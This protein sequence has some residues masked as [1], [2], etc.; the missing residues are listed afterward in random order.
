MACTSVESTSTRS[1]TL[2]LCHTQSI[3]R[4][5]LNLRDLKLSPME[6]VTGYGFGAVLRGSMD[7]KEGISDLCVVL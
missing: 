7:L 6:F 3:S 4:A 2:P 1:V 5:G